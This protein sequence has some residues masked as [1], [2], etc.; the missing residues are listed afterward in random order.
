MGKRSDSRE[1]ISYLL[2]EVPRDVMDKIQ[3]AAKIHKKS[4]KAYIRELFEAHIE[5]LEERGFTLSASEKRT[6]R[7]VK[8]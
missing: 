4:T 5:E 1:Q 2:R 8:A 6:R 3:A 7:R